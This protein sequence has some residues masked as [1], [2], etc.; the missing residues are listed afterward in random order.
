M[1]VYIC[2]SRSKGVKS[3]HQTAEIDYLWNAS[4]GKDVCVRGQNSNVLY[5]SV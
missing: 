4:F 1:L 5:D 2:R 3:I